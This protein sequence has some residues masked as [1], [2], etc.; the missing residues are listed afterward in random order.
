MNLVCLA[1]LASALAYGEGGD[2]V[3][4]S[5]GLAVSDGM[6]FATTGFSP[7]PKSGEKER[8]LIAYSL[9]DP[10]N[11]R[12]VG[13]LALEGAP[14]PQSVAVIGG[15]AFVADGLNLWRVEVKNPAEMCVREKL[16][17]SDRGETGPRA[18]VAST[19]GRLLHVA[20][21]RSGVRTVAVTDMLKVLA[22]VATDFS[23]DVATVGEAVVS[24]E[25]LS[26]LKLI[27]GGRVVS[28]LVLPREGAV[29]VRAQDSRVFVAT[30]G[31]RMSVVDVKGDRLEIVG[32]SG[33]PE[34]AYF[35]TYSQVALPV[36][37]KV[38]VLDGESGVFTFDVGN[39][40]APQLVRSSGM[41][42][43]GTLKNAVMCGRVLYVLGT[44]I[45]GPAQILPVTP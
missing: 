29:S 24:A 19:D 20:C 11:P 6:L 15:E 40:G 16:V 3:N 22:T 34:Q 21:G 27:C 17:L 39:A 41:L 32:E 4:P 35:G 1:A 10:E 23:R 31:R 18:V 26:G 5:G 45:D 33:A 28:S 36:G 38:Y 42:R 7:M 14:F 43:C 30:G 37:E 13:R 25:E 8:A 2:V 12:E 9:A 44:D